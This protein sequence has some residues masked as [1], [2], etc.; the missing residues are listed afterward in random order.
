MTVLGSKDG[1]GLMDDFRENLP[2]RVQKLRSIRAPGDRILQ[3]ELE[4]VE[5]ELDSAQQSL[6]WRAVPHVISG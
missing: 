6:G 1:I 2:K 3:E 5:Y 4:Q